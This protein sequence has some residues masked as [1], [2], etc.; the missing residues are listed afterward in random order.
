MKSSRAPV[1]ELSRYVVNVN[2]MKNNYQFTLVESKS[3]FNGMTLK[4][5]ILRLSVSFWNNCGK[6]ESADIYTDA[7]KGIIALKIPGKTKIVTLKSSPYIASSNLATIMNHGRYEF[8]E[9]H[10]DYIV[11]KKVDN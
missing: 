8:L 9:L 7:G 10:G 3:H 11:C 4:N 2:N 5:N 6:P 1:M